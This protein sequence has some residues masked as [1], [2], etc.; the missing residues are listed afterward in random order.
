MRRKWR[1]HH[2]NVVLYQDD[3]IYETPVLNKQHSGLSTARKRT[4]LFLIILL[5]GNAQ[6]LLSDADTIKELTDILVT[7]Q[8]AQMDLRSYKSPQHPRANQK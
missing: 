5:L 8:H 7:N 2:E 6:L 3:S 4:G 1:A